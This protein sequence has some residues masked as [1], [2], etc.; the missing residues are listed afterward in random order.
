MG[1]E[2]KIMERGEKISKALKE[3]Y[4]NNKHPAF[5]KHLSQETKS[6]LSFAHKGKKLS[7]EHKQ[8]IRESCLRWNREVG[9]PLEIRKRIAEKRR[10]RKISEETKRKISEANKGHTGGWNKGLT[11]EDPRV[12][13]NIDHRIR[14]I[15]KLYREGKLKPPMLGKRHTEETKQK[16]SARL[17]GKTYE[18]RMGKEKALQLKKK[19]SRIMKDLVSGRNNPMQGKFGEKNPHFGKPAKHGKHSFRNDLGHY[20]RSKWEANYCRYLLWGNQKYVYEPKTFIITLP[21]GTKATYTPDFL[22][23]GKEWHELKGWEN[24]SELKKWKF[25]QEQYPNEKFVFINR[26]NYKNL[27]NLYQYIIP[28]WEF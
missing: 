12:R 6:K 18:E 25:F 17:K 13:K 27:Q 16:L 22:V 4:K 24:R 23:D 3:Y 21:N 19:L 14:T 11:I 26:D 5:G 7:E 15:K 9:M 1:E 10:G 28:N 20:C 8:K 2:F